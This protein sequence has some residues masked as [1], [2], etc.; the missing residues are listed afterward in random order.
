MRGAGRRV[1]WRLWIVAAVGLS[2]LAWTGTASA[3][4]PGGPRYEDAMPRYGGYLPSTRGFHLDS[5][6]PW[7]GYSP[8][9]TPSRWV[10]ID[11]GWGCGRLDPDF[12]MGDEGMDAPGNSR[13]FRLRQTVLPGVMGAYSALPP[14]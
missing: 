11:Y 7:G 1:W 5:G 3:Q 13:M 10:W 12:R 14:P 9:G 4:Y 2:G 6:Y 8:W